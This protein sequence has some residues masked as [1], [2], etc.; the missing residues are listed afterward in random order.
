MVTITIKAENST[1]KDLDQFK[2]LGD[3]IFNTDLQVIV[4]GDKAILSDN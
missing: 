3:K 2:E 4:K 1:L